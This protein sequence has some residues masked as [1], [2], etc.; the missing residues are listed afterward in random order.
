MKNKIQPI[1]I[2]SLIAVII[3]LW[4]CRKPKTIK[5][6]VIKTKIERYTDTIVEVRTDTLEVTHTKLQPIYIENS[7]DL[8]DLS[9]TNVFLNKYHYGVKDSLLEASIIVSAKERPEVDFNYK[10]FNTDSV[11]TIKDSVFVKEKVR[12][13]QFYLGGEV[14]IQPMFSYVGVGAD[15]VSR[16]GFQLEAG[17]GYDFSNQQPMIK[18]GY[19]HLI[20]F[21]KQ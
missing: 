9:D 15:F 16:K 1:L 18:V 20:S 12:V 21:R 19:K 11:I 3:F 10:L 8:I 2:L 4:H 5:E 13:N 17:V 7:F 6:E 14:S